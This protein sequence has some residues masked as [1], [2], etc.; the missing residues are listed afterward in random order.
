MYVHT[1][2]LNCA[3]TEKSVSVGVV[4]IT[5]YQKFTKNALGGLAVAVI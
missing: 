4:K 5:E 3:T 1:Y 2:C